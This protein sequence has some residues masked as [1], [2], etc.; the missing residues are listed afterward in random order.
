MTLPVIGQKESYRIAPSKIVAVGLNYHEHVAESPTILDAP[1]DGSLPVAPPLVPILFVK[2][3]NVLVASGEPIV[4][5]T[6][7]L[8]VSGIATPR[9]DYES[10]LA[11]IIGTRCRNVAV[12]DALDCVFGYS[13]FNDVSQREV[14]NADRSG[15]W[16]GKSF[17]SFGPLGPAI[18]PASAAGDPASLVVE[19]RLNGKVVQRSSVAN[20]IFSVAELISY[21]SKNVTLEPGDI[22]ATGTPSG[23][24]PLKAGD[25]FEVEIPGIGILR[26]PVVEE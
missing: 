6:G 26:N 15:W 21:I 12:A 24:G 1:R 11:V 2:T 20:L 22:I 17:D 3:P 14:Q 7:F 19:G 18:L 8:K 5:P 13:C 4:I 10:E 25:I 9:T 16:R 23:V